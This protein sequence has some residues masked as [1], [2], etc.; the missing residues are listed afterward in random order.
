TFRVAG[1][2]R[3]FAGPAGSLNLQ[4]EVF[5]ELWP[6]DGA[7]NLVVWTEGPPEPVLDAIRERVG[8]QQTLFFVYG[9]AFSRY[10]SQMLCRFTTILDVVAGLTAVLGGLAILN[11]LLGAVIERRREFAL[12]RSAGATPLQVALLLMT[13][14][15]LAGLFGGLAG[16]GLGVACAWPLVTRVLPAS[17]GWT[18]DFQVS[19]WQLALL[20]AGVA[21]AACVAGLYP[22][23][24]AMRVAPRESFAPE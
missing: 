2:L 3:D 1:I 12:L 23:R 16:I 20:L 4:I 17:F 14:G 6:R 9:E 5:D 18:L 21:V 15:L 11:L 13:D 8:D 7:R 19:G 24:E 10:V 22:A